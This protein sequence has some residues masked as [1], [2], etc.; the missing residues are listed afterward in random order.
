MCQMAMISTVVNH[1]LQES[2]SGLQ[3]MLYSQR[4][5][6]LFIPESFQTKHFTLQQKG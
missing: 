2:I 4:A 6:C 1:F 3:F 5:V